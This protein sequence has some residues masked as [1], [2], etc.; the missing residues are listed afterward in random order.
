MIKFIG[1]IYNLTAKKYIVNESEIFRIDSFKLQGKA[2]YESGGKH[3]SPKYVFESTNGYS[4]SIEEAIY[5]GIA[6]KK[7]LHDTIQYHGLSFLVY[8][9]KKTQELYFSSKG[10]IGINVLQFQI[11]N[12]KYI[13]IEKANREAKNQL[14]RNISLAVFFLY[15][16]LI[17]YIRKGKPSDK[18]NIVLFILLIV[19]LF[20]CFIVF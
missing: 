15:C 11:G 10:T 3:S 20:L 5:K 14:L 7:E 9:D 12:K 19:L 8:S 6:Y 13:N 18:D 4:F 16:G 1:D 17:L 2:F